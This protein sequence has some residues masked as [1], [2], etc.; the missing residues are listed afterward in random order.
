ME[1]ENYMKRTA[2]VLALLVAGA[3]F[4]AAA[5]KSYV[6]PS[7]GKVDYGDVAKPAQP[8][9]LK[10]KVEFQRNGQH[11]PAV[12]A[13]LMEQVDHVIRTAG[14]ASPA[15]ETEAGS[16]QLTV[17]VNNIADLAEARRKGFGTG[18]TFFIKGSTVT[19]NYEMQVTATIGGQSLAK[20]GYKEAIVT[21]IGHTS[22]PAGVPAMTVTEAFNKVVE[23]LILQF[24]RE[25]PALEHESKPAL[26]LSTPQPLQDTAKDEGDASVSVKSTPDGADIILDGK[27]AGSTPSTLRIKAGDHS[28]R[29]E[30][31]GFNAWEKSLTVSAGAQIT[32]NA[33]LN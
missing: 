14:F 8:Y 33:N 16:D 29:V 3:G 6:D 26:S 12:D 21:T 22:G 11:I 7:F 23:Q 27:F 17:I 10:L 9:K 31:K 20:S 15:S 19:D 30:L 25:L 4:A 13:E 2:I 32:L 18:S 1:G 5:S 24:L 28:I